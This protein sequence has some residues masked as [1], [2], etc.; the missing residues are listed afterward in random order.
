MGDKDKERTIRIFKDKKHKVYYPYG[1]DQPYC[2][3]CGPRINNL[4]Y[5][6]LEDRGKEIIAKIPDGF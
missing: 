1:K 3:V 6:V 4:W 2:Y 5:T